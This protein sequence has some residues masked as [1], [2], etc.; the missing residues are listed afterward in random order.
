[1]TTEVLYTSQQFMCVCIIENFIEFKV[2]NFMLEI[3]KASPVMNN[4]ER[5]HLFKLN[6][7]HMK[8]HD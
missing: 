2:V 5:N 6:N 7:F 8:L 3:V 4:A 1:M